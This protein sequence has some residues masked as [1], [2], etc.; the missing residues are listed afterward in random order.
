[1]RRFTQQDDQV[2][3][4]FIGLHFLLVQFKNAWCCTSTAVNVITTCCIIKHKSTSLYTFTSK[5]V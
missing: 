3:E 1:M 5:T 2:D 4:M